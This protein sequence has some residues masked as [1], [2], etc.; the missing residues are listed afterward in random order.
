MKKQELDYYEKFIKNADIA[1]KMSII[2]KEYVEHFDYEKSEEY[3]K[4]VHYFEREADKN[5]HA[6]LKYL[7]TDFLPPIDREDIVN[8]SNKIDDM[9]DDMDEIVT[10]IDILDI[11]EIRPDFKAFVKLAY[12]MCDNHKEMMTK[13]KTSKKYEEVHSLVVEINKLE[14]EGDKLYQNAIRNL[15]A[16]EENPIEIL[17]WNKIYVCTEK[18]FDSCEGV[19]NTMRE[20]ILKN[21]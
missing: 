15:Y 13:F 12:R 11:K 4:K 5:M 2:L 20:V 8:I 3:E 9:I 21:M 19:A 14:G 10:N 18:F 16:N 1:L 17:K 7:I 6:V